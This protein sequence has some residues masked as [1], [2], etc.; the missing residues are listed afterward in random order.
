MSRYN[1][2]SGYIETRTADLT[3]Y[4]FMK[5]AD[6]AHEIHTVIV[7]RFTLGDV[8][9]PDLYAAEPLWEWQN[10]E[11]GSWVMARAVDTPEWHRQMDAMQY[12]YQYAV[13][14]KLKDV[15]YTFWQ[16][17]WGNNVDKQQ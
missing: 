16:L 9:D 7:H 1:N 14:A 17:K 13:I 4:K 11:M 15:D 12:G 10:S 8:D 3:S 6:K 2:N 5:F